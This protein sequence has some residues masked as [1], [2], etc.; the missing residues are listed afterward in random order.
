MDIS[1]SEPSRAEQDLSDHLIPHTHFRDKENPL[2][3]WLWWVGG[4]Y[5]FKLAKQKQENLLRQLVTV[6]C[7]TDVLAWSL[8]CIM[9]PQRVSVDREPDLASQLWRQNK[10]VVSRGPALARVYP[11][12]RAGWETESEST[13]NGLIK[14]LA[15]SPGRANAKGERCCQP[16]STP[17]GPQP[18]PFSPIPTL[19]VTLSRGN[20][21]KSSKEKC[22]NWPLSSVTFPFGFLLLHSRVQVYHHLPRHRVR[23]M[24]V[25]PDAFS[26]IGDQVLSVLLPKYFSYSSHRL[27]FCGHSLIFSF[28]PSN[29]PP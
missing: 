22:P 16:E 14:I 21:H 3:G 19:Q 24:A 29:C 25:I 15:L 8:G 26:F 28:Q 7:S 11:C 13:L 4:A 5:S 20:F 12:S 2:K 10:A 1:K 23:S 9:G 17:R 18:R 6:R 27:H